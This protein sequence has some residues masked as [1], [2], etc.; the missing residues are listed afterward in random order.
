MEKLLP[1]QRYLNGKKSDSNQTTLS[2]ARASI[3]PPS[4]AK[5]GWADGSDRPSKHI[6]AGW[7]P[8]GYNW[9]Q[10]TY[11]CNCGH[12]W[13]VAH[14]PKVGKLVVGRLFACFTL[15]LSVPQVPALRILQRD[16]SPSCSL[17]G[18]TAHTRLGAM[19]LDG[20]ICFILAWKKNYANW[21][22]HVLYYAAEPAAS[23]VASLL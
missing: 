15:R 10:L 23:P 17:H 14:F 8:S 1:L 2:Q 9:S 19:Y 11:L 4:Q 20:S 12:F 16:P 21:G 22:R 13:K 7:C 6:E 18:D 3:S 5:L